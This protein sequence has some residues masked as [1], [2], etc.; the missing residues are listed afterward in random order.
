MASCGVCRGVLN[1]TPRTIVDHMKG[2]SSYRPLMDRFKLLSAQDQSDSARAASAPPFVSQPTPTSHKIKRPKRS[3]YAQG[4][5][6]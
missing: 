3:V 6:L 4:R 5:F 1:S 2:K